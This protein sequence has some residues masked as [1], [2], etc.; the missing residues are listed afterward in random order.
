MVGIHVPHFVRL[1]LE[2]LTVLFPD[3][4]NIVQEYLYAECPDCEY[5]CG[6]GEM[7]SRKYK[8]KATIDISLSHSSIPA[9]LPYRRGGV[10]GGMEPVSNSMW[11]SPTIPEE[12]YDLCMECFI[13]AMARS[14]AY[15]LEDSIC[16]QVRF[17]FDDVPVWR[18]VWQNAHSSFY[19]FED[20]KGVIEVDVFTRMRG[21]KFELTNSYA[22]Q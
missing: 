2:L 9:R 8:F 1:R 10:W 5:M 20:K 16:I 12:C 7:L 17:S 18:D 6:V 4:P 15:L 13:R 11:Y 21:E 22:R 3:L 19:T 14:Y